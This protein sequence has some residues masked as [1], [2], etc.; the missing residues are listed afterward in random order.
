MLLNGCEVCVSLAEISLPVLMTGDCV[1]DVIDGTEAK[2]ALMA[3]R[4]LVRHG[5]NHRLGAV[6]L[7]AGDDHL[8][9]LCVAPTTSCI[10]DELAGP[11]GEELVMP[12]LQVLPA[13]DKFGGGAWPPR[14]N[15][16]LLRVLFA[17]SGPLLGHPRPLVRSSWYLVSIPM[18]PIDSSG[19][20][21]ST[22]ASKADPPS[23]AAP[24]SA[25]E[26]EYS[27]RIRE[28]AVARGV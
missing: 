13:S 14:S 6:V 25:A 7:P 4:E 17:S 16:G 10:R 27:S 23:G 5:A 12:E 28:T 22:N 21:Y 20:T 18:K 24:N 8:G 26:G 3:L 1:D 2:G 9:E 15:L 19:S 11:L